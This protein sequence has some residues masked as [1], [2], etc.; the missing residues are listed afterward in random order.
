MK[1]FTS[2]DPA[3]GLD[4]LHDSGLIAVWLPELL[5]MRGCAIRYGVSVNSP[6][7]LSTL[8]LTQ[9]TLSVPC[10]LLEALS[11]LSG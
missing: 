3:R 5:E 2:P 4:L 11:T 6:P 10:F 7:A 8:D 1:I 9:K